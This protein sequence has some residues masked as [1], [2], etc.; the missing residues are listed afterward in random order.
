[1]VK[2]GFQRVNRLFV[3]AFE[4]GTQRTSNYAYYVPNV[5]IKNYNVMING[6]NSFDQTVIDNKVIYENIRNI[7]TGKGHDY[8]TACLLEYPYFK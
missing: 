4:N 2:P 3:L 7:A 8:A 6:E 1:M 5:E